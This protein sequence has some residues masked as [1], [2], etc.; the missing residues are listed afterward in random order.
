MCN[1][2]KGRCQEFQ[3]RHFFIGCF[4]NTVSSEGYP[5]TAVSPH[6]YTAPA[7]Q[8]RTGVTCSD[9]LCPI[10]FLPASSCLCSLWTFL[11]L[12]WLLAQT[13]CGVAVV[14]LN[15]TLYFAV[16]MQPR[17]VPPS[18]SFQHTHLL[19]WPGKW[20]SNI[21][22]W[23]PQD[24][25]SDSSPWNV[26]CCQPRYELGP[27][28]VVHFILLPLSSCWSFSQERQYTHFNYYLI[29]GSR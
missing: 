29:I 22:A 21:I 27:L 18:C 4:D 15:I 25:L 13:E 23:C 5:S 19:L 16:Q 2:N 28:L 24:M 20:N 9:V 7:L 6:L 14:R 10:L 12:L 26:K 8:S 17:R 11:V 1:A 3:L